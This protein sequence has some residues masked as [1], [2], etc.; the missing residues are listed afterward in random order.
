[1]PVYNVPITRINET[2]TRRYAGLRDVANFPHTLLAQACLEA[3]SLIVPRG[4]WHTYPYDPEQGIIE[5]SNLLVLSGQKIIT[6]L[7]QASQ[8]AVMAVTVGLK[9]EE[10]ISKQFEQGNYTTGLLMDAAGTAAVE[11]TADKISALIQQDASRIGYTSTSRFSPGYGDWDIT[12]QPDILTLAGGYELD[13]TV[14]ETSML[15]P[16]K[17]VTAIIGLIPYQGNIQQ[18]PCTVISCQECTQ[19]S[20]MARKNSG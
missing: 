13:I 2:E 9:L 4:N 17:S 18:V 19:S 5:A 3:H 15:Q 11:E 14:T 1:M 8:V 6:H 12:V 10:A 20:C 16:R 7:R